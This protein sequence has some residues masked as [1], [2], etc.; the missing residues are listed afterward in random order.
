M[1]KPSDVALLVCIFGSHSDGKIKGRT[2]IQKTVCTL[3]F[4]KKLPFTF[5]FKSYFYGP[6]SD[7]LTEAVNGLIGM[8]VLE[9]SIVPLDYGGYRYEYELTKEGKKLYKKVCGK[10]ESKN[11]GFTEMVNREVNELEGLRIT[12]LTALAKS[13]SNIPSLN[14]L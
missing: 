9:E 7:E 13:V 2:R 6:Y 4:S 12:D 5:E 8:K 10:F 14:V 11:P 1:V 3:E